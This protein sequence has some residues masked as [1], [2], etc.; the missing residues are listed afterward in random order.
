MSKNER[1]STADE[2]RDDRP[3]SRR[4]GPDFWRPGCGDQGA[5][6]RRLPDGGGVRIGVLPNAVEVRRPAAAEHPPGWVSPVG[7][8]DPEHDILSPER[9]EPLLKRT[10]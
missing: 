10:E 9:E 2:R 4:Q 8:S 7:R 1:A 5:D 6:R 3:G